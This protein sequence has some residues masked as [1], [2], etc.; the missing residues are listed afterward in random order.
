MEVI[1]LATKE[2]DHHEI[3]FCQLK[4]LKL[5]YL[6]RLQGLSSASCNLK[7][8]SLET[9][10]ISKRL[11]LKLFYQ[12][13]MQCT[14]EYDSEDTDTDEDASADDDDDGSV[15]DNEVN[16]ESQANNNKDDDDSAYH[17]SAC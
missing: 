10:T 14:I 16:D 1:V 13:E 12:D 2:D 15:D 8:P 11:K 9:L 5:D 7:F 17:E 3:A 6:P 4:Y